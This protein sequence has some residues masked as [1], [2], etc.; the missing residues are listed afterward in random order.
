MES[1][2]NSGFG[3]TPII[4]HKIEKFETYEVKSEELDILS[5][6]STSDLFL[7]FGIFCGSIFFSFLCSLLVLDFESSP[8]A[9]YTYICISILSF[10]LF[11]LFIIIWYRMRAK[12]DEIIDTIKSRKV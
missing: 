2:D 5:K 4:R 3:S 11:V 8:K 7:E 12:R 10:I 9:F 6:N 1:R